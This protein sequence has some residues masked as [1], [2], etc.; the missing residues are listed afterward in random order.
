MQYVWRIIFPEIAYDSPFLMHGILTL[1]ALH[2]A[3]LVP[4]ERERYIE[5]A[6]SHQNTGLAGFRALLHTVNDGNWKPFFCF[7]SLVVFYVSSLPVCMDS[8][9]KPESNIFSIFI[10]IRGV[11]AILEPFQKHL[12]NTIFAPLSYGVWIIEEDDPMY[13]YAGRGISAR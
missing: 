3:H 4:S 8:E 11:R 6:T 2:K 5:L 12:R 9:A 13:L 7:A 10:F 1:A